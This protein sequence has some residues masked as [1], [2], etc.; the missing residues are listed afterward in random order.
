[1]K[2]L[3]VFGSLSDS[4]TYEPL[5]EKLKALGQCQFEIISAHRDP[6]TL[7][8]CLKNSSYDAVVAGAGLAAHLPGVIASITDKAVMGVPVMANFGGLDS[9]M[10]IQQMPFG[11]PVISAPPRH[12]EEIVRFIDLW[13]N[14]KEESIT[15]REI[16]LMIPEGLAGK[17]QFLKETARAKE[18]AVQKKIGLHVVEDFHAGSNPTIV[19][20]NSG[21][22]VHRNRF[23]I[24]V[25]VLDDREKNDPGHAMELFNLVNNGGVWVG[26]NNTRNA[27]IA[28][29][30]LFT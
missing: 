21:A 26:V 28:M 18:Y 30:K 8:H 7:R 3:V 11:V 9:L 4:S 12:P 2:L 13:Q 17:P 29:R 14:S 1:M 19:L 27:M 10:S 24:H 15:G 16:N 6:N 22:H 5:L 25:P 20:T 23:C